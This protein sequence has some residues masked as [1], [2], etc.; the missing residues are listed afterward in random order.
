VFAI[1]TWAVYR[2]KQP[3]Y[4]A[5]LYYA[6]HVHAFMFATMAVVQLASFFGDAGRTVGGLVPL[7]IVPYHYIALG[8]TFGGS[9][10]AVA[11]K[12]TLVAVIYVLT[13]GAILAALLAATIKSV[14]G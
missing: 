3:F 7:T 2:T 11:W 10:L 1:L 8:R 6:L 14:V 5:H 13:V 4:M 12:G 9:R